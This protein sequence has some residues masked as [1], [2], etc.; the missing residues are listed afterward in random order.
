MSIRET[1]AQDFDAICRI[2]E[3]AR[4]FMRESGN[5]DQWKDAHPAIEVIQRDIEAGKSYVY[6]L[7]DEIAA[8]FFYSTERDPTYSKI[9][10]AWLDDEPY[11]VVHR[12]ARARNASGAGGVCLE[13]C[14]GQCDNL[15]IDT[16]RDNAPMR[17]LL[18]KLG[19]TYC[20]IIWLENGEERMAF[21][22]TQE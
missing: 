1:T 5:P 6:T 7:N 16:H 17:K 18:S 11:G 12:I 13:W 9:D 21:Q 2:Y 15:R 22:K 19:F 8:V 10:G 20:G 3:D 14:Y 4:R